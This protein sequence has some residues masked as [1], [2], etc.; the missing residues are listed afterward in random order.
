MG[1]THSNGAENHG[2]EQTFELL[3]NHTL[4]SLVRT[5]L[6]QRVSEVPKAGTS[7]AKGP[8]TATRARGETPALQPR[9]AMEIPYPEPC[10][11]TSEAVSNVAP[12]RGNGYRSMRKKTAEHVGGWRGKRVSNIAPCAEMG[13]SPRGKDRRAHTTSLRVL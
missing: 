9:E 11:S 1:F 4:A 3:R 13:T 6:Y 2:G 12:V 5:L 10:T 7:A 8:F